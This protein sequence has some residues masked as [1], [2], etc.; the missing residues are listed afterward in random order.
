MNGDKFVEYIEFLQ[1]KEAYF[2]QD[3]NEL[4]VESYKECNLKNRRLFE[5]YLS[6][7]LGRN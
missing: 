5:K 2:Y 4:V 6:S 7:N 3:I 1:Q